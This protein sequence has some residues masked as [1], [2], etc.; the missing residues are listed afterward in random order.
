MSGEASGAPPIRTVYTVEDIAKAV[1]DLADQLAPILDDTWVAV[2][3]LLGATPFAADLIR[4]LARRD[5]HVRFDALW[6][7]SY[8]DARESSGRVVVRA[9]LSRS[10]ENRPVLIL[11]EIF[12]SGRTLAYAK[13][14]IRAKG[15]AKAIS[16]ALIVK[17]EAAGA[18]RPDLWAFEAP[19]AF[20]VGYGMDDAGKWRGLPFIG[21]L[22]T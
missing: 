2:A 7:E 19:N 3:L 8:R 5:I 16:T 11:D 21:A 18:D 14:H 6:L 9:D 4:A 1:D 22:E 12:D 20:L 10:V 15:A 13:A 17:P